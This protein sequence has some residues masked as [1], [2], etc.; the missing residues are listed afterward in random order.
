[1]RRGRAQEST[2]GLRNPVT[3]QDGVSA[4]RITIIREFHLHFQTG[5]FTASS[6]RRYRASPFRNRPLEFR[7]RLDQ[8]LQTFPPSLRE[9]RWAGKPELDVAK[10]LGREILR[11]QLAFAQI[12]PLF[13]GRVRQTVSPHNG[14]QFLSK[15]RARP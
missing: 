12:F 7:L 11:P 8:F 10:Q 14:P 2:L 15:L 6:N 4:V 9:L 5:A 3:E 13:R 1:V